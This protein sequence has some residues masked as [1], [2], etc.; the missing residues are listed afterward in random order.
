MK[1]YFC[2]Y[3]P[4]QT[5]I[6]CACLAENGE[7]LKSVYTGELFLDLLHKLNK[8]R[9]EGSCAFQIMPLNDALPML[10]EAEKSKYCEEWREIPE[11]AWWASLE[12]L[13]PEKWQTVRGVEIFRMREYLTGNITAHYARLRGKFFSRNCLTS[14]TYEDLAEQVAAKWFE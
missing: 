5:H 8:R 13:P 14:E 11:G 1:T 6:E 10:E 9:Q 12:A 3:Q 4:G 2:I 7:E